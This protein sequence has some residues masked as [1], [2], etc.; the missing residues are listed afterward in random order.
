MAAGV[1]SSGVSFLLLLSLQLT[2]QLNNA[3]QEQS[4]QKKKKKRV[5]RE[6]LFHLLF[7]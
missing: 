1:Q 7:C 3:I 5:I 6:A 4:W 2:A